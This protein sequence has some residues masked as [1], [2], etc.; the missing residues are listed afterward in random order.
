MSGAHDPTAS[1]R[2]LVGGI[3]YRNLRD[4][5]A[6]PE[7]IERLRARPWPPTVQVEDL[8]F[9]AVH[10]LH[11]LQDRPPFDMAIL[12]AAVA[13][14]RRPG[15]VTRSVWSTPPMSGEAVQ[16]AIAEAV[17]GVIGLDTLLTVLGYFGALPPRL[18]VVEIEPRDDDWGPDFSPAVETALV[19]A[20]DIVQSEVDVVGR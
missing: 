11:W 18:I 2:I 16:E 13:R 1:A 17:T 4:M 7:I 10:V 15:A 12:V 3:G 9:G 19:E 14:G 8:S 20:V 6:G 5:S